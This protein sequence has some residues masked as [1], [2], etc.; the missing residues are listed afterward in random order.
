MK[1][2]YQQRTAAADFSPLR[3]ADTKIISSVHCTRKAVIGY[4]KLVF[5]IFS[6][7]LTEENNTSKELLMATISNEESMKAS[8]KSFLIP[9]RIQLDIQGGQLKVITCKEPDLL[10][11]PQL[12]QSFWKCSCFAPCKYRHV[13]VAI[14]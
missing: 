9:Y 10:P 3:N 13:A 1:E 8:S 5:L 14:Q 6:H 4:D 11:H 12:S 7:T 2:R